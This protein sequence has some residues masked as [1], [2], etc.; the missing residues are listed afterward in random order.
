MTLSPRSTR[1][2]ARWLALALAVSAALLFTEVAAHSI[3][4]S[5]PPIHAVTISPADTLL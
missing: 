3:R 5:A 1:I 4:T 2:A